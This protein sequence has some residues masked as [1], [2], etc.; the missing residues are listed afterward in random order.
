MPFTPSEHVSSIL[1]RHE[2]QVQI[3]A[4]VAATASKVVGGWIAPFDC[5]VVLVGAKALNTTGF[6]VGHS[7][8]YRELQIFKNESTDKLENVSMVK[9]VDNR[10]DEA[11]EFPLIPM[12]FGDSLRIQNTKM[13]L[14]L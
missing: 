6:T 1:G 5:D 3:P 13:E 7:T 12:K 11:S 10:I 4:E 14:D 9:T 8:N 2:A